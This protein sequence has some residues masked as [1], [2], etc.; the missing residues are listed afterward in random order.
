MGYNRKYMST[1]NP[2][3]KKLVKEEEIGTDLYNTEKGEGAEL[4]TQDRINSEEKFKIH[5]TAELL[6]L[7]KTLNDVAATRASDALA[8]VT[9]NLDR[10][11]NLAGVNAEI[12]QLSASLASG[13]AQKYALD[14]AKANN[15]LERLR[16]AASIPEVVAAPLSRVDEILKRALA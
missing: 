4:S 9:G 15:E 6:E 13:A 14:M 11:K 10:M 5:K 7:H 16:K 2:L 8:G 12:R 3:A 1:E